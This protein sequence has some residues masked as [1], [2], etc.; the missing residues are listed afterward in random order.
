[1]ENFWFSIFDNKAELN[2]NKS[3]NVVAIKREA[4][5]FSKVLSWEINSLL[6]TKERNKTG[7]SRERFLTLFFEN[8][9]KKGKQSCFTDIRFSYL[10]SI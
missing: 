10:L 9:K 5:D 7:I 8:V 2:K 6:S 1:M 3:D 4:F